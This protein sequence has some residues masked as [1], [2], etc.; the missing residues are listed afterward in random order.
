M[1]PPWEDDLK[2]FDWINRMYWTC[3]VLL[4]FITGY[5]DGNGSLETDLYKVARKYLCSWFPMDIMVVAF[6]WTE[7]AVD[8]DVKDQDA[9]GTARFLK[10]FKVLRAVRILRLF[11]LIK[12]P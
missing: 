1:D 2:T 8:T 12:V 9:V 4:N 7:V 10:T 3:D 11:R 6:S 5:T